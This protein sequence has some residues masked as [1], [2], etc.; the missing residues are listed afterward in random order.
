MDRLADYAAIAEIF[1]ALTIVFSA[2]FAA[3]QYLEYRKRR[4]SEAAAELCRR[5]AEPE[6]G[7]AVN[8][9]RGL[10]DGVTL[11]QIE[12]MDPECQQ[13][14]QI[15]GMAFETMGLMVFRGMASFSTIQ[16][17]T[18][19]LLLMMWR[20]I[21]VWVEETRVEQG[22]PRFAEWVQWLAERMAECEQ[23]K[24]PAHIAHA[25]WRRHLR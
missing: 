21:S 7:R 4:S 10:P 11:K 9:V 8:V 18:G 17:L 24:V 16:D 22:N 6:L 5:F 3:V 20:K 13:A 23:H 12:A 19:G 14:A 1:G 25:S 2:L 15:V